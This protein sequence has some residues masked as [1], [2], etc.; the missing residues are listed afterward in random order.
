MSNK[1]ISQA[2]LAT[3]VPDCIQ[4]PLNTTRLQSALSSRLLLLLSITMR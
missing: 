4:R 2:D 1:V 3:S